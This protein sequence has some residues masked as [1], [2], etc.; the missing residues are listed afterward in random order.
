VLV[1][2]AESPLSRAAVLAE[3]AAMVVEVER[4]QPV[5]S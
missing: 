1:P 4:D 5:G 3:A 2:A